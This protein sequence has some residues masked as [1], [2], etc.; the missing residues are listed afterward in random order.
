MSFDT[1][2]IVSSLALLVSI[3]AVP[4][5]HHLGRKASKHDF[6]NIKIDELSAVLDKIFDECILIASSGTFDNGKYLYQV[7]MY[8]KLKWIVQE[9][10]TYDKCN[11]SK[12]KENLLVV[13]KIMTDDI[14]HSQSKNAC[15]NIFIKQS[16]ILKAS[17]E[18]RF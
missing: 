8:V 1:E 9:I 15:L 5:T 4:I 16:I 17:F 3:F 6:I 18:R 7:G 10:S 12:R 2:I 14:F 11:E 13:K